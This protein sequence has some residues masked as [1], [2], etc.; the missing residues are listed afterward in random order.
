VERFLTNLDRSQLLGIEATKQMLLERA[1]LREIERQAFRDLSAVG[2]LKEGLTTP[3]LGQGVMNL[4][5]GANSAIE[6]SARTIAAELAAGA[7]DMA[8]NVAGEAIEMLGDMIGATAMTPER[9]EAA[10]AAREEASEQHEIDLIRF[11]S[12]ADYRLQCETREREKVE[13]E[14]RRYYEQQ[15]ERSRER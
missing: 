10:I 12:D 13:E 11:R 5:W 3:E 8:A 4:L 9:I 15:Q 1:E 14:Q 7:A 2:V 6:A